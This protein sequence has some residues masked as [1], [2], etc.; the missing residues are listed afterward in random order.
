MEIDIG[1]RLNAVTFSGNSEYLVSASDESGGTVQVWRVEDGETVAN[2]AVGSTVLCLAASK[3][4]RWIA[5]GTNS[6]D[7]LVWSAETY[8]RVFTHKDAF[9]V[10]NGVDFSPDATRLLTVATDM[11]TAYIWDIASRRSDLTFYHENCRGVIA[12]KFSPGGDQIATATRNDNS[13]QVYNSNNGR[14]LLEIKEKVTPWYNTG[15]FWSN[16]HLFVIS[17]SKIKQI[18]ASTG[19]AIY[20]WP[21]P[22]TNLLSCIALSQHGDVITY[23][24]E[25]TVAFLHTSARTQ[26]SRIQRAQGICSIALSPDDHF[27]A[28][29]GE[30]GKITIKQLSRIAV[31]IVSLHH[32]K[33]EHRTTFFLRSLFRFV[34]HP[35]VSFAF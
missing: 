26:L 1:N 33:Y 24:A 23:S 10:I 18:E 19:S 4:G 27:L 35:T 7:A 28:I 29:G 9:S 13:V 17:N 20:E 32:D 31:S 25:R 34:S 30:E 14:C 5:A 6:G 15:L 11:H 16:K 8:E 21:V 3:D 12:A 2:M 22:H